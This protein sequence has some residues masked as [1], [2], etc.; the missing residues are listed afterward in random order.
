MKKLKNCYYKKV[1]EP[2]LWEGV[3]QGHYFEIYD[4]DKNYVSY[5]LGWDAVLR[6]NKYGVINE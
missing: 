4:L 3:G 5:V 1:K 6:Y 2:E